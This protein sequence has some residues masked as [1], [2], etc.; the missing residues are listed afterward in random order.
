MSWFVL[1][2]Y[3]RKYLDYSRLSITKHRIPP[4]FASVNSGLSLDGSADHT[5][6][7]AIASA[8]EVGSIPTMLEGESSVR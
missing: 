1:M 8:V 4:R 2:S 6:V 5:V 3:K 7:I